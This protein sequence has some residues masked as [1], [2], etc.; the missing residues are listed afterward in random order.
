MGKSPVFVFIVKS[1]EE[2]VRK[3]MKLGA[4]DYIFKPF[5]NMMLIKKIEILLLKKAV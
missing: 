2:D 4:D 5:N 1:R 3:G